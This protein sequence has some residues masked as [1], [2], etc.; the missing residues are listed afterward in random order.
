MFDDDEG[1]HIARYF[2]SELERTGSGCLAY[3]EAV[4]EDKNPAEFE[5]IASVMKNSTARVV[6]SFADYLHNF[7]AVVDAFRKVG[8][9]VIIINLYFRLRSISHK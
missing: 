7:F 5:R 2:Q 6:I 4:P 3:V 1:R 8:L 9:Y